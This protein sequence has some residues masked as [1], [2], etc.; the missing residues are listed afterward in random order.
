VRYAEFQ[1]PFAEDHLVLPTYLDLSGCQFP[2]PGSYTFE[3]WFTAP[4]GREVQKAE[5]PFSV[6]ASEE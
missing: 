2:R 5:Q 4:D 3:V 6:L 1:V